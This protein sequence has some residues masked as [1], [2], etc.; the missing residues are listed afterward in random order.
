MAFNNLI[1]IGQQQNRHPIAQS[2]YVDT[3]EGIFLTKVGLFFSGA[4]SGADPQHN[5]TLQI[6]PITDS[7]VPSASEVIPGSIAV[8]SASSVYS[9]ISTDAA[10]ETTFIFDAPV[11]LKGQKN[12]AIVAYSNSPLY[13]VY[14]GETYEFK[15][16]TTE[17]RVDKNPKSGTLFRS[18]N[19]IT[20]TPIQNTDLGF[21]L[22]KAKFKHTTAEVLMHNAAVP[23]VNLN[24]NAIQVDSASDGVKIESWM[25]GLQSGDQVVIAGVTG[26]IGGIAAADINGTKPITAVD[27]KTIKVR[28]G[29]YTSAAGAFTLDSAKAGVFADVGGTDSATI[30][31]NIIYNRFLPKVESLQPLNTRI[32]GALKGIRAE[33]FSG[34]GSQYTRATNFST[35]DLNTTNTTANDVF[36]VAN[37]EREGQELASGVKSLD[38]KAL[39]ATS[40]PTN[41]SPMI[42]L[43]RVS[44][45]GIATVIDNQ[46]YTWNTQDSADTVASG[47]SVFNSA[48]KFSNEANASGGS[49][50]A[51]WV[52]KI[53]NLKDRSKGIKILLSANRPPFSH[54]DMYYRV[55]NSADVIPEIDWVLISPE[56]SMPTDENPT[57]YRSYEYLPGGVAGT[58]DDFS[59][60]QFKIVMRSTYI[61]KSPVI[62]DF[63]A[64]A[65]VV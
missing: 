31:K 48:I 62:K 50:A 41:V 53:V 58:L 12:Y 13:K 61:H 5:I 29:S 45:T 1:Q 56:E 3:T 38:L 19:S 65:L 40:N 22:Y 8:K 21:K 43:Q 2:F 16:G 44:F 57:V 28:A 54:I 37:N 9:N 51:R 11:F 63:R 20:F 30:T 49:G 34:A 32:S 60:M 33:A 27:Y 35:I 17:E 6:R 36:L 52:S 14:I 39:L 18:S 26:S 47:S 46:S 15:V 7:G 64:I 24:A 25:H 42:D 59:T 4:P 10:T 55:A 23:T